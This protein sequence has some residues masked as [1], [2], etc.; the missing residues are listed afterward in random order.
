MF[1][2]LLILLVIHY[3]FLF[4]AIDFENEVLP[5]LKE[6][7]IECH[8]AP[9]EQ[10]GKIKEPKAGLRLDGATFI[11]LGG[12]SGAVVVANHPSRSSLYN[13]VILPIEDS[14]HMPPKGDPLSFDQK[15]TIRKWIAQGLDFGKWIGNSDGVEELAQARADEKSIYTPDHIKFYSELSH[16]L[17][18]LSVNKLDE[19]SKSSGLMVR[20]I[21]KGNPLIEVRVVT[22]PEKIDDETIKLLTPLSNHI[23]KLDLRNSR[24][25]DISLSTIK[26]FKKL[27]GLNLRGT[28]V[29]DDGL[30]E[31]LNLNNLEAL[32]VCETK[33]SDHGLRTLKKIGS[34]KKIYF[35]KSQ[36]TERAYK[37]FS[38]QNL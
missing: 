17:D 26:K 15:E 33:I 31:I 30:R 23:T 24:I 10:N 22:S 25:T 29:E 34:L 11:M 8:Q 14:E 27:T 21:S 12:D 38:E 37:N 36:V 6:R 13:R 20:Q 7:C 4:S 3:S 9:F 28:M 5:I 1:N 32:N 19:I 2:K 16:N 18:F 35:W